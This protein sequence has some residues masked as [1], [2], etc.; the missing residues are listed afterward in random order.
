VLFKDGGTLA[1]AVE[2]CDS[3][4]VSSHRGKTV[5]CFLEGA[6]VHTSKANRLPEGLDVE[7]YVQA[8]R[9]VLEKIANKHK[10][11]KGE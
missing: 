2:W 8:F 5:Q 11:E 6:Q 9:R 10:H 1:I 3:E 4:N 7:L